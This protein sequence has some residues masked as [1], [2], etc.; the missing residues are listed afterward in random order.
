MSGYGGNP[1]LEA[2]HA[3][4]LAE[5]A[6]NAS[7][8]MIDGP[9]LDDCLDCGQPISK[10]RVEAMRKINMRCMYCIKCQ[11][12]HDKQSTVKMLDRIL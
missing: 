1:D 8:S 12:K 2:E 3:L 5:N 10:A 6:I 4:I 9:I 11:P 7:R